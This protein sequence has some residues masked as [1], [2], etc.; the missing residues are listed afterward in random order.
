MSIIASA[1][2][3]LNIEAVEAANDLHA[4]E[5]FLI[6]QS[7]YKNHVSNDTHRFRARAIYVVDNLVFNQETQAEEVFE[8][9]VPVD[10]EVYGYITPNGSY[11]G[12]ARQDNYYYFVNNVTEELKR[13][14][15]VRTINEERKHA[16]RLIPEISFDITAQ[17]DDKARIGAIIFQLQIDELNRELDEIQGGVVR[18]MAD[19]ID[20]QPI[21]EVIVKTFDGRE[22]VVCANQI[23]LVGL[24]ENGDYAEE[25]LMPATEQTKDALE[26]LMA[27]AKIMQAQSLEFDIANCCEGVREIAIRPQIKPDFITIFEPNNIEE[28]YEFLIEDVDGSNYAVVDDVRPYIL[29][30]VQLEGGYEEKI[31]LN[32]NDLGNIVTKIREKITPTL[33]RPEIEVAE[34]IELTKDAELRQALIDDLRQQLQALP[35]SVVAFEEDGELEIM[36]RTLGSTYSVGKN[37]I[38][39]ADIGKAHVFLTN[40][41]D[42]FMMQDA[43]AAINEACAVIKS[44]SEKVLL[45][46]KKIAGMAIDESLEFVKL[47]EEDGVTS[48]TV[49]LDD[50]FYAINCDIDGRVAIFCQEEDEVNLIAPMEIEPF[51]DEVYALV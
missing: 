46:Y 45:F 13:T 12:V 51:I 47:H 11:E 16:F 29:E 40:K 18:M 20:D 17:E 35:D 6:A 4:K 42:R 2:L 37:R 43:A 10:I 9:E 7:Q 41:Q 28:C 1:E 14:K 15:V 19:K 36:V 39:K 22:Y 33:M 38:M 32:P 30:V 44:Q 8:E 3:E 34:A 48:F 24:Q 5:L 27:T 50:G 26:A 49:E 31:I 25:I 23:K 21:Y